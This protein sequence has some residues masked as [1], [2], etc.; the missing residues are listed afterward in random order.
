MPGLDVF[1]WSNQQNCAEAGG[2]EVHYLSSCASGRITRL[3]IADICSY[4]SLFSEMAEAFEEIMTRNVNSI[5]QAR[6]VRSINLRLNSF[7]ERGGLATALVGTYFA[8]TKSFTICN[9]G[10]PPPL[11]FRS[12]QRNWSVI[13]GD[14]SGEADPEAQMFGVL[15]QEEYRH[16]QSRL[17]PGDM[18]LG[19]SNSLTECRDRNGCLLGVD[20]LRQRV[21]QV[22]A[23]Q[24]SAMLSELVETLKTENEKNIADEDATIVLCQA[25]QTGVQMRDN[26][27]APFRLLGK[28]SNDTR[29]D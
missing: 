19:I 12:E 18:I 25:T 1:V 10:F 13:Q 17:E 29:F 21:S 8:P 2:R 28:V 14:A 6:F 20:G 22:D 24:P 7:S 5:R 15:A 3:M 4:G 27:L 9:A 23:D 26:F 16:F 11:L